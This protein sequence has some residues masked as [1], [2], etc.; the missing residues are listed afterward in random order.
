M[1]TFQLRTK[2]TRCNKHF[3]YFYWSSHCLLNLI[4]QYDLFTK[5]TMHCVIN[6]FSFC[7]VQIKVF[8]KLC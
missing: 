8:M 6:V 7:L 4:K 5:I 2:I 3:N 1:K